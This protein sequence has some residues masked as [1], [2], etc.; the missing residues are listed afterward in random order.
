MTYIAILIS[1]A[2]ILLSLSIYQKINS[3]Q[4]ITSQKLDLI[5]SSIEN[6]ST[7]IYNARKYSDINTQSKSYTKGRYVMLSN[8][9]VGCLHIQQ[10]QVYNDKMEQL[11]KPQTLSKM[12]SSFGDGKVFPSSKATNGLWDSFSHTS[13]GDAP[14]LVFDLGQSVNIS[15]IVIFNREDCCRGRLN[16]TVVSIYETDPTTP[17]ALNANTNANPNAKPLPVYI[18]NAITD[19]TGNS[20]YI[21]DGRPTSKRFYSVFTFWPPNP[22]WNGIL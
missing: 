21:D 20:N 16:G 2:A 11:I 9:Q 22:T 13:C 14:W 1:I 5:N 15:K 4:L 6:L 3:E 12:S 7:E 8:K 10:I 18:S 19:I 17:S